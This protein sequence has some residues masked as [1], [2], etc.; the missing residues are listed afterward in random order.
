MIKKLE[1]H[2][3]NETFILIK[4]VY[5]ISNMSYKTGSANDGYQALARRF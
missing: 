4:Y 5:V 2:L 3:D 1:R